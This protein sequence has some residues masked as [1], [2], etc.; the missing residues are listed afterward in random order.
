MP[1]NISRAL[2]PPMTALAIAALCISL[3]PAL[4]QAQ[5]AKAVPSQPARRTVSPPPADIRPS[6]IVRQDL[7]DRN[8]PNNRRSDYPAPPAQPGQF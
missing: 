5:D 4:G 6:G 3:S 7:F 8:N 2:V 1:L